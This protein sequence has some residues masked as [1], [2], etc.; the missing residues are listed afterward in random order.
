MGGI[1]L[2]FGLLCNCGGV[3][4]SLLFV[5]IMPV[6]SEN[7]MPW[8]WWR[9]QIR[10]TSAL[11]LHTWIF[12]ASKRR[13]QEKSEHLKMRLEKEVICK[14]SNVTKRGYIKIWTNWMHD[15]ALLV[16][17][18]QQ[19]TLCLFMNFLF[20]FLFPLRILLKAHCG[21][22][23]CYLIPRSLSRQLQ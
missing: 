14:I 5:E 1:Y 22:D 11:L 18:S 10:R 3:T 16:W 9:H 2:T 15:S 19:S 21:K 20:H 17:L 13:T 6:T 12:F 8:S 4:S 23:Y 7:M